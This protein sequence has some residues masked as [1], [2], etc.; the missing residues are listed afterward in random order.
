MSA[1]FRLHSSDGRPRYISLSLHERWE[2]FVNNLVV[3]RCTFSIATCC[4]LRNGDQTGLA[5][6]RWGLTIVLY[7]LRN[8]DL[9][10]YVNDLFII[11]RF[12]FALFI[13]DDMWE[14]NFNFVSV[15]TPK[16]FSSVTFWI[17]Y[18]SPLH[19]L[20]LKS[21][22]HLNDQSLKLS[23][24][25]CSFVTSSIAFKAVY[26]LVSSA[27]SFTVVSA[28]SGKSLIKMRN[29]IGPSQGSRLTRK[30]GFW[31]IK[32][33]K[34]PVL[35]LKKNRSCVILTRQKFRVLLRNSTRLIKNR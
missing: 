1:L 21:M 22:P 13:L 18:L 26:V 14:S 7:R 29:R 34:Y 3:L 33:V 5:Y 24:V 16:S 31:R 8:I 23:V 17:W 20:V 10:I 30:P 28:V 11:P 25:H 15:I 27:N 4:F 12:R 32:I 19:F 2:I 35:T 6:S 9:S